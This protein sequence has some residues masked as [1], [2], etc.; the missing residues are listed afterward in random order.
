MDTQSVAM[1]DT[2]IYQELQHINPNLAEAYI[3]IGMREG[4]PPPMFQ[5][6][7]SLCYSFTSDTNSSTLDEELVP[8]ETGIT[9]P[10][11]LALSLQ[12]QILHD[13]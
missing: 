11:N 4:S 12:H 10:V 2:A 9:L 5:H 8:G 7:L 3:S 13:N 6:A 1:K